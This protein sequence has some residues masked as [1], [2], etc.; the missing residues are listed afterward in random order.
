M[1]MFPSLS[2]PYHGT[3]EMYVISSVQ[4]CFESLEE[5]GLDVSFRDHNNSKYSK[6][7]PVKV[8]LKEQIFL[9][10]LKTKII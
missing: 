2:C 4:R 6:N 8:F 3:C 1:Y 10:K 5:T 7:L 9:V